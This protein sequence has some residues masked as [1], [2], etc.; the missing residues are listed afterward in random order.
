MLMSLNNFHTHTSRCG[1]ATGEDEEYV[2]KAIEAGI[3]VLGF[4]DHVPWPDLLHPGM[5]MSPDL[6]ENYVKSLTFLKNKYK[7]QIE[8][9]I[10]FEAEYVKEYMPYYEYL[11]RK[12]GIEYFLLGQHCT[13]HGDHFYFYNEYQ[14]DPVKTK[15]YVDDLIAGM[16]SGLFSYVAHPDIFLQGYHFD[17]EFVDNQIRRICQKAKVLNLP[18]ELNYGKIRIGLTKYGAHDA[19]NHYPFYKFWKVVG[20]YDIPVVLGIDAHA[21]EEFAID[22][23]SVVNEFK[24]KFGLRI[25]EFHL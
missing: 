18:L 7:N 10:G 25:I 23:S 9:H 24:E 19:Y 4:S 6:V 22:C 11:K 8:I 20:E 21:P 17:D 15:E 14:N 12:C 1:H 5:R 3:K 16:E 2:Q 13:I